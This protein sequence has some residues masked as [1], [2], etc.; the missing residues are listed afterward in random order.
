M[1]RPASSGERSRVWSARSARSGHDNEAL[2]RDQDPPAAMEAEE[3][4]DGRVVVNNAYDNADPEEP[5]G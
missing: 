3:Y 2:D 4:V 5:Q 1:S